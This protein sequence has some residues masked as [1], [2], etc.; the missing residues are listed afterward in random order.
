LLRK[1]IAAGAIA[2]AAIPLLVLFMI[3]GVVIAADNQQDPTGQLTGGMRP[4]MVPAQYLPWVMKAGALCPGESPALIAAQLWAESGFNPGAHS[5]QGAQG[6]AQFLPATFQL[7]SEDDDGTGN[8]SPLN[9][10]DA[11]MAQGRYMCSLIARAKASGYPGGTIQL[12]LAGYNA[13]WDAVQQFHGI[14]PYP[15]TIAYITK[16]MT[17]AAELATVPAVNGTGPGADALQ[18]GAHWIGTP[19]VW[20]G[21][22]PAG[23]TPGFCDGTNGYLNGSCFAATHSG[24]DCSSLVQYA[25]WPMLPL[26]RTAAD[27][28]SATAAR[29]VGKDQLQPG[30]LLFWTH[31]GASGIY[32]VA[33]YWG[34]GDILQEPRTGESAE[35]VP[36]A[37]VMPAGDYYGAT[38]PTS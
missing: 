18:R 28:Y 8:I 34:N 31:G 29:P 14:P 27:Q 9:P 12:A 11:I 5:G 21:G 33:L 1:G 26:P 15:E 19:Y 16:I 24:F 36:L 10:A 17:K 35:I 7:Y 37:G 22:T 3:G 23:P 30:D 4:G 2:A 13:G 25:Y 38:R 20:G 32:H 6:I